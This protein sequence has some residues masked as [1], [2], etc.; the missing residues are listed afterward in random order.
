MSNFMNPRFKPIRSALRQLFPDGCPDWVVKL[1][2][3]LPENLTEEAI[4]AIASAILALAAELK[5]AVA[6]LM[7]RLKLALTLGGSISLG[8]GSTPKPKKQKLK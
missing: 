3:D 4:A 5:T 6:D 1:V 7:A 8:S 2:N